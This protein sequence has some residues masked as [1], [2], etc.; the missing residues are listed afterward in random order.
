MM[1][2]SILEKFKEA[3]HGTSW[4]ELCSLKVKEDGSICLEYSFPESQDDWDE[5]WELQKELRSFGYKLIEISV[6]PDFI[7][8]KLTKL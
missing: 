3:I 7:G 2:D 5:Y 8:G 4:L 6:E 1:T